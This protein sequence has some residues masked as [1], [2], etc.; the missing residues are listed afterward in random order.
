MVEVVRTADVDTW[1]RRLRD[2]KAKLRIVERLDRLAHGNPGNVR[3]VGHGVSELRLTYGPGYR[4]YYVQEA[5]RLI[6]LLC[7]G[8]KSTQHSDIE[9]AHQLAEEWRADRRRDR[10][11]RQ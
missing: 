11:G 5:D 1:L 4:I 10:D 3:P 8:D 6:L 9:K 2:R 7:G